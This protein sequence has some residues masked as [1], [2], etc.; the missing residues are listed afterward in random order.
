MMNIQSRGIIA[1]FLFATA[2]SRGEEA[3]NNPH[4]LGAASCNSSSCH[5]G[6]SEKSN[7]Y[8]IWSRKDFHSRSYAT[9]TS[10]R[11]ERFAE[12]LK[13]G[14]ATKSPRCTVCH[15]PLSTIDEALRSPQVEPSHGV[16]CENCHGPAEPWLRAHTRP[17][18]SHNDRVAAGMRDLRSL[19]VRANSCV[20]CHQTLDTDLATA[21]H[22]ELIFELDGQCASEPRHWRERDKNA[23]PKAWLVGQ[24]VALREMSWQL[25]REARPDEKLVARWSALLWLMQ[26]VGTLE[27]DLPAIS[28]V[29]LEP[30][31]ENF[32]KAQ[33]LSDQLAKAAS[34]SVWDENTTRQ[35][36]E[37]LA[38]T[39]TE[40]RNGKVPQITQACRA[41]RLVLALDRLTLAADE[42]RGDSELNA[43]FKAV[44]SRPDFNPTTFSALLEKFAA[45][46]RR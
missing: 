8:L 46:T 27:M 7:Q 41:E 29:P 25:S 35:C 22:P 13:L 17:D 16:S 19:Y 36:L 34:E 33:E 39:A 42:K 23:G 24:A 43:M 3:P 30:T 32:Q 45:A 9:L 15:A 11:S 21:G 4:F 2:L 6:A 1:L 37:K 38:A 10:A 20:A 28:T 31:K 18:F 5:G 40:F 26:R 14:D 12:V 44:H